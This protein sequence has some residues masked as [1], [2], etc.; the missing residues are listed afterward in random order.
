MDDPSEPRPP[1][2]SQLSKT[3][4]WV[5]LGFV[6][7]A[8]AVFMLPRSEKAPAP[9]P[10]IVA[11]RVVAPVPPESPTVERAVFFEDVFAELNRS[12]VWQDDVTEVAF[13]NPTRKAFSDCYEVLKSGDKFYFRSIPHL[14]RPVL[15]EGVP[16]DSP[17]Q[18]TVPAGASIPHKPVPVLMPNDSELML[19]SPRPLQ[20]PAP[21]IPRPEK[22][23]IELPRPKEK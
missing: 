18:F 9:A 5:M 21:S 14:T 16:P 17:L 3:P 12:A 8:A 4:S 7:G 1:R 20:M 22:P 10:A 11:P 2:A 13:W 15:K 23:Q 19:T 6:L